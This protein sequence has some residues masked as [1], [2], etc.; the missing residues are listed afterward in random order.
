MP[1]PI[2]R[3]RGLTKRFGDFIAVNDLSIEVQPGTIFAFLG[4]N[5]SG[6]S[7]TI[8]MLIGL[9]QPSGGAIE[10]DGIDVI[11]QPRRVRDHI[12]YMGQKVSLYA[13][14]SLRENVEFYAGLYGLSGGELE[15]R[16]GA[17]RERFSLGDTE[18]EKAQDLPGGI[19]QRAGLAL[20]T[21]HQPRVLFLDEPTAGVDV[22]NRG[23]FWELIQDEAQMGVTVFVT[24]HF[25][26]EVDYCDWVSFIHEGRLIA[27]DAPEALRGEY[28]AGYRISVEAP[29]EARQRLRL[30]VAGAGETARDTESG[31][32]LMAPRPG[33]RA[34]R[35]ARG[36]ARERRSRA[37][38]AG[39][40]DRCLSR[41]AGALAEGSV[42]WRRLRTLMRREVL[43]TFRDPFTV[44]ILVAV[45]LAALLVFGFVLSTEVKGL[46]MG[47]RDASDSAASRRLVADLAAN[48]TFV[49][50]GYATAGELERALVSGDISVGV[51]VPPDFDRD[52]G[53]SGVES[54][55]VQVLYDGGEAVLAGNAEGFLRSLVNATGVDLLTSRRLPPHG[56]GRS[57]H[58][59][60]VVTRA[61]FNPT[62][63][64]KP[65]MVA[66]TFGFVLSFLT[67]LITAVS[68]V[69]ER[70]T[71]TFEQ[72]Q[73]TPATSLEI[74]LGKIL[75]LG[76]VFALDVVL[77]VVVAGLALHVWPAGSA[78]F[79]IT[80][81]SFYVLVSLSLGLIISAT[82][83]TAA[84][85]VQKSVLF[86]IPLVQLS[87]FAFPIRNM[88]TVV[89]WIAEVFPATHYIRISRAIYMRGEG[90]LGLA[91]ELG[92]LAVFA[93]LL[94]AFALRS[95]EARR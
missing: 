81:S 43:A 30:L 71:G 55:Q 69:T 44:T 65:F 42:N 39:A 48:G 7:T 41:R 54:P 86:S 94:M 13:G 29:A 33:R 78:L 84:E 80:V 24:T 9:L 36:A 61:L 11:R 37:H 28:S 85:A 89:Q 17:L 91:G 6:K 57:D 22:H 74:F 56:P 20:S 64:G 88:P 95:I 70:L 68:I 83:Q 82:S 47:V 15:R 26:E 67:T 18:D 46:A 25:L 93:L 38:R 14:L 79:F 16:W 73:V 23:L 31:F 63:D 21:L 12:G 40:D 10:V 53:R 45:P 58:G 60:G 19:R 59:V 34:A 35:P 52:L 87:G 4:A 50:R 3:A 32:E 92:L 49:P 51:V 77:M 5:G 27:D 72:L 62:L 8:R 1:E 75:P 90:P 2:I 66:G 76:G